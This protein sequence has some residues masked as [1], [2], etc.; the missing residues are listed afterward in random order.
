MTTSYLTKT[1][2]LHARQCT[3][4]FWLAHF[5]PDHMTPPTQAETESIRQG[6]AV[7]R[8]ARECFPGGALIES[9]GQAAVH[10]TRTAIEAGAPAIFE[11]TFIHDDALIR[12][13]ILLRGPQ[14]RWI[15]IEVKSATRVRD[16][17][18]HDLAIQAHVLQAAGL[19][20][21]RMEIMHIN[22]KSCVFPDLSNLFQRV[23]VTQS[24]RTCMQELPHTLEKIRTL[25]QHRHAPDI[26][27]GR[28]CNA[29]YSCPFQD[30][31]WADIPETSI[32][33]VPRL[34]E[35]KQNELIALGI[36]DLRDIPPDFPLTSTQRAY[37]E[38]IRA[39]KPR[40]DTR[41]IR[42]ALQELRYPLYFFDFETDSP[43]IPNI[44][45]MRP[46]QSYPFQYSCHI[47]H[48]NGRTEHREYL[49]Q[50]D[51]DPRPAIARQLVRDLGQTGSVIVYSAQFERGVLRELAKALPPYAELMQGIQARLWDQLAVMRRHYDHPRFL[52]SKSIK[53]VLP[54]L[55]PDLSYD[56]LSVQR[57]DEAQIV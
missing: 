26:A 56:D 32:F 46:Y 42:R 24:V 34:S 41:G 29:P 17:Y 18:L 8:A 28:H 57:G 3:K 53:R 19:H 43:A 30:H 6:Q 36:Y 40:I 7:G 15:L 16:H 1:T 38:F 31:C 20:V 44:H 33:T 11:A 25:R 9:H 37:V 2:Y 12:C 50:E 49:H 48:A 14:N 13:D 4:R 52:N 27:V 35:E 10:Q 23:D 5:A 21:A 39:G 51:N 22:N 55:V 45:G 54:V 47:V